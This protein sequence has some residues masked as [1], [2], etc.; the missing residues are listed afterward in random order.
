MFC[1]SQKC[2]LSQREMRSVRGRKRTANPNP[3]AV[4]WVGWRP[5]MWADTPNSQGTNSRPANLEDGHV[6]PFPKA[7]VSLHEQN[8][9]IV[10]KKFKV[11]RHTTRY[12]IQPFSLSKMTLSPQELW[13]KVSSV[14]LHHQPWVLFSLSEMAAEKTLSPFKIFHLRPEVE[15]F[16]AVGNV[17]GLY[18]ALKPQTC[19]FVLL[20][21]C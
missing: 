12:L 1:V 13:K 20:L 19:C 5:K 18:K 10:K 11:Q 16:P 14:N 6:W 4:I 17:C 7:S 15:D 9:A 3:A 2:S 8:C 21:C